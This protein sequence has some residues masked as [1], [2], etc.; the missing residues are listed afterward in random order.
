M[1]KLFLTCT[2]ASFLASIA[3]RKG[4]ADLIKDKWPI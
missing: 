2:V 3:M 4:L 1:K